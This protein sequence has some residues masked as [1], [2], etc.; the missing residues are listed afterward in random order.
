MVHP[1]A[2]SRSVL[3]AT[4]V[5]V[6]AVAALGIAA[7]SNPEPATV[8]LTGH[9]PKFNE[10]GQTA[11]L[12]V[13]VKDKRGK[14]FVGRNPELLVNTSN[15][16][17]MLAEGDDESMSIKLKATGSGPVTIEA[18]AYGIKGS[19]KTDVQIPTVIEA[20]KAPPKRMRVG[21]K[22]KLEVVVKDDAGRVIDKPKLKFD[23]DEPCVL[24][25]RDGTIEAGAVGECNV[26]V[27]SRGATA[28]F[29]IDVR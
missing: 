12:Q 28:R 14:P 23:Q 15:A 4:V 1:V 3:S 29:P 8:E 17:V 13:S 24:V 22:F 25:D 26:I 9:L 27:K 20:K 19:R 5:A 6:V 10:K 11:K 7:C 21:K 16:K 18:T 2:S